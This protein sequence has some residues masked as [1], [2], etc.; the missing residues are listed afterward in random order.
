MVKKQV[1]NLQSSLLA[2]ISLLFG[3]IGIFLLFLAQNFWLKRSTIIFSEARNFNV[4]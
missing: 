3:M 2:M 1:A 4:T